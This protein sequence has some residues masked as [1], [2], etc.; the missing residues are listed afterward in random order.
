VM[1]LLI[2]YIAFTLWWAHRADRAFMDK[3]DI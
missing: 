3:H 1:E 2:A